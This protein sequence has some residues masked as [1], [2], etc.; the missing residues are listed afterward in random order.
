MA[1]QERFV[2]FSRAPWVEELHLTPHKLMYW[3]EHGLF[4]DTKPT[5]QLVTDIW[6]PG[7]CLMVVPNALVKVFLCEVH[8]AG[9]LFT[10]KVGPLH[11]TNILKT[12][13][14]QAE[15]CWTIFLLDF[16]VRII[17]LKSGSVNARKYSGPN[18]TWSGMTHPVISFCWK[19][20]TAS[21]SFVVNVSVGRAALPGDGV[22]VIL[23]FTSFTVFYSSFY[24]LWGKIWGNAEQNLMGHAHHFWVRVPYEFWFLR[25]VSHKMFYLDVNPN[26]LLSYSDLLSLCH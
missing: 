15:L 8:I 2:C 18:C 14:H 7:N 5:N 6:E 25:L 23:A 16:R 9:A 4:C 24:K 26:T 3:H 17:D 11:A 10:H 1:A 19:N 22:I 12:L 13:A 21:C 20:L